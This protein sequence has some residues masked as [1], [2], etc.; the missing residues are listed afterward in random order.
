M[1][2][3]NLIE[4]L[5]ESKAYSFPVDSVEV[6]H[7]HI[8]VV[9]LAGPFAYK[10]KKPV[11]LGFLDFSTLEKR[12][13]F[14]AEE[15]RLNRRL[16][17]DVYLG[18]VPLSQVG[19]GVQMEGQGEAIEWAVKM[20]RLPE[21]ATLQKRLLRGQ[22]DA[23]LLT[24]LADK[25]ASFHAQAE[26]GEHISAFGRFDVVARNARENFDQVVPQVGITI[27]REIFER[28]RT[29]TEEALARLRPLIKS[30][31]QRGV[32]RDTHGDMHLDHVYLLDDT[33][34]VARPESS[35]GG[36][37]RGQAPFSAPADPMMP[38]K[39]PDPLAP[40]ELVIIDC[41]EFNERFRFADP[42][43]DMAFLVMDLLFHKRNDLAQKFADEYF[44]A[45]Q[46]EEGRALLPFYVAY[47]AAVRG[48]V[49]GF[50]LLEKEIP[51]EER[52]GA[53]A[54]A[55]AHW[56]LALREL[57]TPSQKPCLV[58]V[59]GLPGAGKST[60]AQG[61]ADQAGFRLIRSD[62]V[63]KELAKISPTDSAP[64]AFGEGI[65]SPEWTTRT[66]AECLHRAEILL[67]QGRRVI[68][69]ASFS[70][71]KNRQTFVQAAQ[72][73]GVP[74][75]FLLCQADP[76]IVRQRLESRKGDASDADWSIYQK[77]KERWEEIGPSTRE[78][79]HGVPTA[80]TKEQA[81]AKA[82][83]LLE[84]SWNY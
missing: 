29:L 81:I 24:A 30:R 45:A 32:P 70:Q 37:G 19:Q 73:L 11:N 28:L 36:V 22:V 51:Q 64:S 46:D 34:R 84:D 63:R 68:V 40:P 49:E 77:A 58:L 80:L 79:F 83:E 15:V 50:E 76:E 74:V 13:H 38:K 21:E 4:F 1:E 17:P 59:G 31:A 27:S 5:S 54:K 62:L 35:K 61:L 39:V 8:S 6:R 33:F 44:R 78:V 23:G 66:Y 16:A 55:R 53:L 18:V 56:L 72:R 12:R 26:A 2:L 82:L 52:T 25:V 3:A 60:L 69:D 43:A 57:E 48:K 67:F 71:E 65:Y 10:I 47:R 20:K 7:T 75:L 42:V 14:C 41:I 9:F